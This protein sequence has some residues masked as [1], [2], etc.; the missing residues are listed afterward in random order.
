MSIGEKVVSRTCMVGLIFATAALCGA[1]IAEERNQFRGPEG[2]GTYPGALLPT[3]WSIAGEGTEA[4][5]KNVAWKTTVPGTGWSSP[6]VAGGKV[7]VTSAYAEGQS[8]P[9]DMSAGATDLRSMRIF[10]A[11]KPPKEVFQFRLTCLDLATGET[12][13]SK[14]VA[15]QAPA[16]PTHPSNTFATESPAVLGNR[17]FV[18][19]GSVGILAAYDL[20]GEELWRKELPPH[21]MSVGFGTG[22]SLAV[23][24]ARLYLQRDN[25]KESTLSAVDPQ[26]GETLWSADRK[27]GSSWAT[28]LVWKNSQRTEIVAAGAG[29]AVSYDP[30]T[31]EELWKFAGLPSSASASPT[32]LG[33]LVFFGTS[34]PFSNSPL[35]AVKAGATGDV[36]LASGEKSNEFV[37]WKKNG[38]GLGMASPVAAAGAIFLG[39]SGLVRALDVETGEELFAERLDKAKTFAA[40]PWIAGDKL[41]FLDEAGTT[42]VLK[43][44][45]T[46]E[47]LGSSSLPETIWSTPSAAGKSLVIRGVDAIYC[48]RD[49]AD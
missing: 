34:G 13:W 40:S 24:D 16:L 8:K 33:D 46:F 18:F 6:I 47:A 49:A 30:T 15:E 41:F 36:S 14:T 29:G 20:A 1:S 25:E 43:A 21:E 5:G 23:D 31:G 44:G 12:L 2:N 26:S 32:A 48:L 7:F 3:E 22:S 19:F 37:A 11:P 35:V 9:K 28:P 27:V 45:R 10:G 42:H 39:E 38:S 4:T 17:V